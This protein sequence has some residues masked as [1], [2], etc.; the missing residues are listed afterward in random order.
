MWAV[1]A[2][3]ALNGQ[4]LDDA[5]I[6]LAAIDE[7]FKAQRLVGCQKVSKCPRCF[8]GRQASV[9]PTR[10]GHSI[11]R[12]SQRGADAVPTPPR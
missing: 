6:A 2:G 1:L 4:Q 7:V 11:S 9:Y 3:M 8:L 5:E 10:E 12:W